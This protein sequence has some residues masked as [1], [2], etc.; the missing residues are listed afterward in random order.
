MA[1]PIS[2][3]TV[4]RGW[5]K[6]RRNVWGLA[7]QFITLY[8]GLVPIPALLQG[9]MNECVERFG[10][11]GHYANWLN[12]RVWKMPFYF[13]FSGALHYAPREQHWR[14]P[15]RYEKDTTHRHSSADQGVKSR[16]PA[17]FRVPCLME[18]GIVHRIAINNAFL[19]QKISQRRFYHR[20][21]PLVNSDRLWSAS[22]RK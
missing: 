21:P 8:E 20:R 19:R 6:K 17:R 9:K 3:H 15:H 14:V 1:P 12:R 13:V 22:G 10:S 5:N 18:H 16:R 7:H 11:Q 4:M 2:Q